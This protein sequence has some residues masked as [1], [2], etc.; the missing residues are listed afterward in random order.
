MLLGVVQREERAEV[1]KTKL[2]MEAALGQGEAARE[3]YEE[4]V[5]MRLPFLAK[6]ENE[7]AKLKED[8]MKELDGLQV[9]LDLSAFTGNVGE[10]PDKKA[11]WAKLKQD[12]DEHNKKETV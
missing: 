9:K 4:Y 5:S 11:A 8:V 6:N 2:L 10:L 7:A 1:L 3:A 12:V